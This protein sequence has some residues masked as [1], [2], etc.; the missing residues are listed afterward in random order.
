M[1]RSLV[2]K[3][4]LVM[5]LA[6][7]VAGAQLPAGTAAPE[8]DLRT[9]GGARFLLSALRGHPVV[10]TFWGTWCPP[11][12]DELPALAELH[13]THHAAGLE[14]VAVNQGDQERRT[15]DVQ[16]FVDELAIPFTVA[17]DPRGRSR[18]SYRLI[19]LP[20]TVFVDTTGVIRRVVSGP[21]GHEQL[22]LGLEAIG[23]TR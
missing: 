13:R 2:A 3:I 17:I 8:I 4:S 9:L 19:G 21:F 23:V 10:L 6:A 14:I 7:P 12:R 22:T 1:Q 16:R 20:T 5:M 11:C 18:R 15:S